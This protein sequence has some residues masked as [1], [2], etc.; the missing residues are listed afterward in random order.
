M[1]STPPRAAVTSIS[2]T[3]A[4]NRASRKS[5]EPPPSTAMTLRWRGNTHVPLVSKPPSTAIA[6]LRAGTISSPTT[7]A[8]CPGSV[9]GLGVNV[10]PARAAS[11]CAA[12][13]AS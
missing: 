4:P 12:L 6:T 1:I 13:V 3:P 8:G 7:M 5:I 10:S 11:S 2:L 9:S